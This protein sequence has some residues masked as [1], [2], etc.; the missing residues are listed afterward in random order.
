MLPAEAKKTFNE[1]KTVGIPAF[2]E[3]RGFIERICR[4][5][6]DPAA[7]QRLAE[8]GRA[9]MENRKNAAKVRPS[10]LLNMNGDA[11]VTRRPSGVLVPHKYKDV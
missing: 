5:Y 8:K 9:M 11:T 6:I 10:R 2:A 3:A 7:V 4:G 1:V